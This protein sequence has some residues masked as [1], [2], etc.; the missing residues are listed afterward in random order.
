MTF[1]RR[2]RADL[3]QPLSV[4][5]LAT[6][7]TAL[8]CRVP[9][10]L[11]VVRGGTISEELKYPQWQVPLRDAILEFSYQE[12]QKV[13][14]AVFDRFQILSSD[15]NHAE[16]RQALSDALSTLRVLKRDKLA[17]PDWSE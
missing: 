12:L 11:E 5:A 6:R 4:T 2:A 15:R 10:C 1:P 14:A 17:F 3:N 9:L 13:E 8:P 16:E 7:E